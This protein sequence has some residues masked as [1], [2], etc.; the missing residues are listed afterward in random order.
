MM[1]LMVL[2]WGL[3]IW[4]IV[5]LVRGWAE[6]SEPRSVPGREESAL[7]VLKRRYAAGEISKDEYDAMKRD[8]K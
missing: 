5:S 4:L 8:L 6:K 2:F 1:I 7:E 3:A